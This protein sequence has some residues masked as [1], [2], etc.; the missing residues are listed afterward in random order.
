MAIMSM[1]RQHGKK[2][3]LFLYLFQPQ[4]INGNA[5]KCDIIVVRTTVQHDYMYVIGHLSTMHGIQIHTVYFHKHS[6]YGS[7]F[8]QDGEQT[9][10]KWQRIMAFG[11]DGKMFSRHAGE[12]FRPKNS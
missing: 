2:K 3:R 10:R 11:D 4:S 9:N 12:Q 1:Y 7:I 6:V 5:G 8:S